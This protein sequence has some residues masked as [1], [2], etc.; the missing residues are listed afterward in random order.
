MRNRVTEEAEPPGPK[1]ARGRT[2]SR[3][4]ILEAAVSVFERDGY[5]ST[6][7]DDIAEAAGVSRRTV[8]HHFKAKNDILVAA[9]LEQAHLFLEELKRTVPPLDDFPSFVVESLCF[10]IRNAPASRFFM[11]QM[12]RGVGME[13]ATIYFKDKALMGEWMDHFREPY[14]E[15]LRRGQINPAI[16][17]RELLTWFGRIATSF[18]QYPAS[19]EGE[20]RA[21][22]ETFVA[23]ALRYRAPGASK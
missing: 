2:S 16:E 3:H 12:A 19:G 1:A 17:L 15:A 11:L 21:M 9:T 5:Q 23:G 7:I 14:I 18:L 6:S 4:A 8:Y 22:L 10:V 20:P 13:S